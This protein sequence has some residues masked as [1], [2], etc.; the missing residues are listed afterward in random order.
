[1]NG[2]CKIS[3]TPMKRSNLGIVGMGEGEEKE[4]K[5][6]DNLFNRIIAENFPNF[7]K[8]SPRHRKLTEHQATRTKRE[9]HPDTS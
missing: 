9:T 2:T 4:T 8:E 7:E 6:I 1:M 5:G 3:G